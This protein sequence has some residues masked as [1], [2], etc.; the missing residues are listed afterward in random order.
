MSTT[1]EPTAITAPTQFVQAGEIRFAYRRFGRPERTPLLFVNHFRG[2]LESF[3]PLISD[4]LASDREVILFDNAGVGLSTGTA[5]DTVEGMARD[6]E[7]FID[8]LGLSELDI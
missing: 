6:A 7:A 5:P 1:S 3:D 8:A 4:A 2:N